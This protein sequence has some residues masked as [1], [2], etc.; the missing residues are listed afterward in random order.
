MTDF[1]GFDK[2]VIG[3]ALPADT[4]L[5]NMRKADLIKLLHLAENNHRTLVEAY[6]I[7]TSNSKCNVCPL[8]LDQR[9]A[10]DIRADERRKFAEWFAKCSKVSE[11]TREHTINRWIEDYLEDYEKE[12]KND[13]AE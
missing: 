3:R 7:A 5:N 10:E 11:H 13:K 9:R 6:E 4:T 12:Q 8:H 1:N 2:G